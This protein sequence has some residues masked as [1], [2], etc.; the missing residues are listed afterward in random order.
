MSLAKQ[1]P[2]M[3]F[4]GTKVVHIHFVGYRICRRLTCVTV[5]TAQVGGVQVL[6]DILSTSAETVPSTQDLES[7]DDESSSGISEVQQL[8]LLAL[9][10][11]HRVVACNLVGIS[12]VI[13]VGHTSQSCYILGFRVCLKPCNGPDI[14]LSQCLSAQACI[15]ATL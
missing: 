8:W 9:Q 11:L 13:Q 10:I 6:S 14:E 5:Q 7:D 15:C 2:V 4:K 12:C 3:A 1:C